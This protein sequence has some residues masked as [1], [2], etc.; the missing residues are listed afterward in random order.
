LEVVIEKCCGDWYAMFDD[1]VDEMDSFL[2]G[3]FFS[4]TGN[5]SL[6]CFVYC[7]CFFCWVYDS[8]VGDELGKG[9]V[10]G[11]RGEEV[12]GRIRFC[13]IEKYLHF[14]KNLILLPL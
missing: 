6:V 10:V 8:Y 3:R 5:K 14:N 1:V 9:G 13:H 11:E 12:K 7:I 2:Y 4:F